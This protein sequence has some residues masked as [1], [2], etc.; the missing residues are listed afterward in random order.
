[1]RSV[2]APEGLLLHRKGRGSGAF[3]SFDKKTALLLAWMVFTPPLEAADEG[4]E[5]RKAAPSTSE[6]PI[7]SLLLLPATLLA[8]IA[9]LLAPSE[10]V[11]PELE[12]SRAGQTEH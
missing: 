5:A 3:V 9:S 6:S 12:E 11:K 8:K 1:M 7:L 2:E 10:P 4:E